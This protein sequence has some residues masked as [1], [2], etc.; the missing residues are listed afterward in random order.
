MKDQP[1]NID[2]VPTLRQAE[3]LSSDAYEALYGGA[4]GGGKSEAL[5]AG[6]LR[7][8]H[9]PSFRGLI[10]RRNYP[11]LERSLIERSRMLY[12]ASCPGAEYNEAKRVWRFPSG[13]AIYFGHLEHEK[14]KYA[15]QSAEFAYLAFDELTHFSETQ[16]AY[17]LSRARSSTGLPVF[18]RAATNPGGDGHA[19]VMRRWAPWLDPSS[20]VQA[21]PSEPLHY[22]NGDDGEEWLGTHTDDPRA[23]S[24]VFIAAK[25]TDN[26]YLIGNDPTYVERLRGLDPLTRA[27]LLD[28]NWLAQAGAGILFKPAWFPIVDA[29]P[30]ADQIVGR[31]R[32][33]DRAATGEE[34]IVRSGRDADYTVGVRLARSKDGVYYL[35]DVVRFRGRPHEVMA[36]IQHTASLDGHAVQVGLEQDPAQAGQFEIAVY[37]RALSGYSIRKHRPTGDKVTRAKPASAQSEAGNV[38]LLRGAWNRAFLGELEAFPDGAHDDQVDA[39][40][41]GFTVLAEP[42]PK[43]AADLDRWMPLMPK[44][45]WASLG[46]KKQAPRPLRAPPPVAGFHPYRRAR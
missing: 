45:R 11:D 3:F 13:A 36:R 33:W 38:K 39:F 4:A 37:M 16:Y 9:E 43:I 32:Y 2:W 35:E 44:A 29:V 20:E 28:G 40:S 27:Q 12:R 10:L 15:Y 8:V 30:S 26:P 21:E 1:R 34:D 6:A 5:L 18:V 24:R 19:W 23:L 22:R 41:G 7:F 14:D 25:V 46:A 31:V 17:M 42:P